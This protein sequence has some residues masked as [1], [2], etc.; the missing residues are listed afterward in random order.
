LS[1][2]GS[3]IGSLGAL[4]GIGGTTSFNGLPSFFVSVWLVRVWRK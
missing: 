4:L 3:I 1:T 2:G